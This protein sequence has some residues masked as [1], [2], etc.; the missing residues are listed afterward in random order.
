MKLPK[1]TLADVAF[2]AMI[3][4]MVLLGGNFAE[5]IVVVALLAAKGYELWLEKKNSLTKV[6]EFE[7]KI[8]SLEG[9]LLATGLIRRSVNQNGQER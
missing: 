7:R 2:I 6:E 3:A 4:K 9:K 8:A 5:A 1:L